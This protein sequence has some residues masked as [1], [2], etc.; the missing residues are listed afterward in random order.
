MP[1]HAA[2]L[3]PDPP[4]HRRMRLRQRV[5]GVGDGCAVR[6][7]DLDRVG[8]A[9]MLAQRPGQLEDDLY[10]SRAAARTESTGGRWLAMSSQWSPSSN[11]A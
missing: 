2:F 7:V 10:S 6:H 4:L 1:A 9:G 8:T 3:V 11:E 5:E